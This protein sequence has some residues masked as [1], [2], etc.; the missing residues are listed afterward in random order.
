MVMAAFIMLSLVV[1][2][3]QD[4]ENAPEDRWGHTANRMYYALAGQGGPAW[5]VAL[6]LM[7]FAFKYMNEDTDGNGDG[8]KSMVK[9]FL[10]L[11]IWQPLGKLTYVMYLIHYTLIFPWCIGDGDLPTYYSEWNELFL[12][13]GVWTIVASIGF[14]LWI[15]M[16]RPLSNLVTLFLKCIV[17]GGDRKQ[18]QEMNGIHQQFVPKS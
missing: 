8:Q 3:Y 6:S 2:P 5:G 13:I 9:A 11:E 16:E 4:V 1:W 10:S 17:G 18:K 12:V 7:T 15:V 14:I